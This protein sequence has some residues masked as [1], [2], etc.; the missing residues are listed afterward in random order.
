[1]SAQLRVR[2]QPRA[3]SAE[4]AGRRAG[5]VVVRV[6]APPVEGKANAALCALLAERVGIPRSRVSV[7][8]GAGARDKV[9]RF[10]GVDR[11]RLAAALEIAPGDEALL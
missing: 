1:M 11:D 8:R 3:K 9:V 10:E 7:V 2:V 6:A 4:I 5:A